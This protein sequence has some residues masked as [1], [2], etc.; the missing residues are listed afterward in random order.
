MVDDLLRKELLFRTRAGLCLRC[1]FDY[2]SKNRTICAHCAA[3][4]R[5]QKLNKVLT[6]WD[7]VLMQWDREVCAKK[8]A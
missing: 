5:T 7:R 3:Q 8:T 2:R 1:G 4:E 6:L